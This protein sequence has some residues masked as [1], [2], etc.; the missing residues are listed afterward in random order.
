MSAKRHLHLLLV[1]S[2]IVILFALAPAKAEE[3]NLDIVEIEHLNS[4]EQNSIIHKRGSA[5]T[6]ICIYQNSV[7]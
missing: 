6:I 3:S 4:K 2:L 7:N 5:L 1:A